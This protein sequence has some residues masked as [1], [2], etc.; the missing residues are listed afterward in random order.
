MTALWLGPVWKQRVN[1]V[2][3]NANGDGT[4]DPYFP[5]D[6]DDRTKSGH[7]VDFRAT[8]LP[9]DDYHAYAIQDF[10]N[11]DPRSGRRTTS[12]S[13]SARRTSAACT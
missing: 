7:G 10:G 1:G 2:D 13:S 5:V 6:P 4:D 8:Q 11:V 3:S 9:R 12:S